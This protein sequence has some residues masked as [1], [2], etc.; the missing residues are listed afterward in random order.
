[1][2]QA[3]KL[4]KIKN[5]EKLIDD[6]MFGEK[7]AVK[8]LEEHRETVAR[9]EKNKVVF[10]TGD[11]TGQSLSLQALQTEKLPDPPYVYSALSLDVGGPPPPL[12]PQLVEQ[13][14]TKHI[15]A[16]GG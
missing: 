6:L 8:I 14:F 15:K 9:G 11:G 4:A 10:S 1:M 13:G 16:A 3:E 2:E 5:K 12:P 7:D